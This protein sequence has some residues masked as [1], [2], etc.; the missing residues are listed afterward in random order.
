MASPACGAC[1]YGYEPVDST[2]AGA[3]KKKILCDLNCTALFHRGQCVSDNVCSQCISGYHSDVSLG[4]AAC[5]MDCNVSI[6]YAQYRSMCTIP[7]VCGPCMNGTV[8]TTTGQC[9]PQS[10]CD[11]AVC[12]AKFRSI[13]TSNGVCGPCL[14]GYSEVN[15]TCVPC[16]H[17][18]Y[19]MMRQKCVVAEV[20]GECVTGYVPTSDAV[21][22]RCMQSCY[23]TQT[24]C[25]DGICVD[26]ASM[27]SCPPEKPIKCA[28][29]WTMCVSDV[30]SC[31]CPTSSP[32]R[33]EVDWSCR[34]S[35]EMCPCALGTIKCP[36]LKCASNF[37]LCACPSGYSKCSD[38]SC[39]L[40]VN[41]T[42]PC[43]VCPSGL[44][45]DDGR[46]VNSM[47]ECGSCP[48][49]KPALCSD[50]TCQITPD[51]CPCP[52]NTFRCSGT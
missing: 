43:G 4:N 17:A 35:S 33:C 25:W 19:A 40:S 20:C 30:K 10:T 7:N 21:N 28:S 36:D 46:C 45:C 44:K 2:V 52:A 14:D 34:Q 6:C 15:G 12:A 1:Y 47:T 5:I 3:C 29:D 41:N 8:M 51:F 31:P 11:A 27:C 9:V 16:H 50:G 32:V 13:C 26:D 23:S 42:D 18:C 37:S 38:F 22:T 24:R 48:E 39:R 49:T